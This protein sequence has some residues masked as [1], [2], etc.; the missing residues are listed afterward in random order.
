MNV[1]VRV[2]SLSRC[3]CLPVF[4]FPSPLVSRDFFRR[5]STWKIASTWRRVDWRCNL[6]LPPPPR[7]V[8]SYS[9]FS[10]FQSA[11]SLALALSR[12]LRS[13]DGVRSHVLWK[14]KNK[15]LKER[16]NINFIVRHFILRVLSGLFCM[17]TCEFVTHPSLNGND[18]EQLFSSPL[19]I[20]QGN[21]RLL[22]FT[23]AACDTWMFQWSR[24]CINISPSQ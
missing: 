2:C 23:G 4:I 9:A 13:K 11:L 6:P 21:W 5:F 10:R 16:K 14:V 19:S 15:K 18:T 20:S 12:M 17:E 22:V 1:R 7:L 8:L 24:D 3:V